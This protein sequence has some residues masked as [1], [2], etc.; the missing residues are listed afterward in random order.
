MASAAQNGSSLLTFT[1]QSE[2]P[3]LSTD[4]VLKCSLARLHFST[5]ALVWSG[6]GKANSRANPMILVENPAVAGG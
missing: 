5:V 6:G 2:A 3:S 1:V 4:G